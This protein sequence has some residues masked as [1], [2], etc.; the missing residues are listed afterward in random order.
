MALFRR[1]RA[2]LAEQE[3]YKLKGILSHMEH[4][5]QNLRSQ[6]DHCEIVGKII[7]YL[8]MDLTG[9]EEKERLKGEHARLQA[10]QH[11]LEHDRGNDNSPSSFVLI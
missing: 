9:A 1:E 6:G 2:E 5:V 4:V 11:A 7:P 10:L 8:G 3:G